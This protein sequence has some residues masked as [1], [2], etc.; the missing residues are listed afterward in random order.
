MALLSLLQLFPCGS[1]MTPS[2]AG[3]SLLSCGGREPEND[4]AVDGDDD[5]ERSPELSEEGYLAATEGG[6]E[7]AP[8]RMKLFVQALVEATGGEVLS[9]G[10]LTGFAAWYDGVSHT[11]PRSLAALLSEVKEF[12]DVGVDW[13]HW[14]GDFQDVPQQEQAEEEE[15]EDEQPQEAS[16]E[17]S[18]AVLSGLQSSTIHAPSG[19]ANCTNVAKLVAA[20]MVVGT[21]FASTLPTVQLAVCC[22]P[23][24][25]E[26]A[27]EEFAD[28]RVLW[29]E[30]TGKITSAEAVQRLKHIPLPKK[31]AKE[32]H[33]A[34][35]KERFR[36]AGLLDTLGVTNFC[37]AIGDAVEK[38]RMWQLAKKATKVKDFAKDRMLELKLRKELKIPYFEARKRL[39]EDFAS[40]CEAVKKK[41]SDFSE[42]N[43]CGRTQDG[44]GGYI[45]FGPRP[46]GRCTEHQSFCSEKQGVRK[47]GV[48][49]D[50]CYSMAPCRWLRCNGMKFGRLMTAED[51]ALAELQRCS[52]KCQKKLEESPDDDEANQSCLKDCQDDFAATAGTSPGA[53]VEEY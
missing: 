6:V 41:K 32:H 22:G 21:P 34:E 1:A 7:Q 33:T 48:C 17:V 13:L 4:V 25:L 31:A 45:Y 44:C 15:D 40:A 30:H 38:N 29:Q 46:D 39:K 49:D 26:F 2:A 8:E 43:E 51:L 16:E 12:H 52:Q 36:I 10:D 9:E 11:G 5:Q 23:A 20:T 24:A 50:K 37:S 14:E 3:G 47:C 27:G 42:E 35:K 28:L 53:L 19:N 18:E